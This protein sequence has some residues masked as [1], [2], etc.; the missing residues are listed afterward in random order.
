MMYLKK[1]NETFNF[2]EDWDESDDYDY[3]VGDWITPNK[4]VYTSAGRTFRMNTKYRISDVKTAG[5]I[6]YY[7][8]YSDGGLQPFTESELNK[9]FNRV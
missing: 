2:Q 1:Y 8:I 6:K 5:D 3:M 9:Y 4:F 7:Y